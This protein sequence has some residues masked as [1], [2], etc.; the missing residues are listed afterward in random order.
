[1]R[2]EEMYKELLDSEVGEVFLLN[3]KFKIEILKKPSEWT[4]DPNCPSE[5]CM[6]EATDVE[7]H[8]RF[9]LRISKHLDLRQMFGAAYKKLADSEAIESMVNIISMEKLV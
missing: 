5:S 4:R 6:I 8:K 1:M 7:S 9:Q 2:S 3:Q